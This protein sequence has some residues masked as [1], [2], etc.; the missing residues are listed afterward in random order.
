MK[1][2]RRNSI[3]NHLEDVG[4]VGQRGGQ[5]SRHDTTEDIDHH[6]FIWQE[7]D[8]KLDPLTQKHNS[9]LISLK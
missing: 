4:G 5:D 6:G 8:Q 7:R 2:G 1:V 3:Q 9:V